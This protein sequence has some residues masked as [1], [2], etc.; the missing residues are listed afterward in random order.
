MMCTTIPKDSTRSVRCWSLTYKLK[1]CIH[2]LPCAGICTACMSSFLYSVWSGCL[3]NIFLWLGLL[4]HSVT[5]KQVSTRTGTTIIPLVRGEQKE[6]HLISLT[7]AP[8]HS[9]N[10]VPVRIIWD[11]TPSQPAQI[12]SSCINFSTHCGFNTSVHWNHI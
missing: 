3:S 6:K 12:Q 2:G 11:S 9:P 1:L 8:F 10:D 4:L 7:R 5:F